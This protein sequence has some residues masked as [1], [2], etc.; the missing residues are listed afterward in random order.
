MVVWQGG[1]I[2]VSAAEA[3]AGALAEAAA[4]SVLEANGEELV[5]A[6]LRGLPWSFDA[7]KVRRRTLTQRWEPLGGGLAAHCVGVSE[8]GSSV[9]ECPRQGGE[10]RMLSVAGFLDGAAPPDRAYPPTPPTVRARCATLW[11]RSG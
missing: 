9:R 4:G 2:D 5:V 1:A 7:V 11:R 8:R 3:A 6:R 10:S